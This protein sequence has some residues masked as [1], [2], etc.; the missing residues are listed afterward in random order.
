MR[1]GYGARGAI[2]VAVGMLAFLAALKSGDAEGTK[3]ALAALRNKPYGVPM[4]WGIG[5]GLFGYLI[6]RVAAGVADVENHGTDAKGLMARAGQVGTGLLHGGIGVSVIGLALGGGGSGDSA[7]DWT[8]VVMA[9]PMGRIIVGLG[10]LIV[11]GAGVF[12]AYKG[13]AGK[14]K[15]HLAASTL[16]QTL[17][18]VIKGGLIVYGLLLA[19]VGLSIATAAFFG[20]PSQAGGLGKA[21]QDLRD[22]AYGRVLLG[23]AGIGL[24]AFAIYNFVEAGCRVVPK[25]SGPDS[26]TLANRATS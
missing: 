21:L 18:P 11:M 7:Q 16:T 15:E 3:D 8:Q 23:G 6:W 4:L 25:I 17:E 22:V 5:I 24:L 10:A 2:Y 26:K 12:Y 1:A 19:L 20:D 13:L 9:M 14:Y